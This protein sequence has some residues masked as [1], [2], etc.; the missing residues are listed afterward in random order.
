MTDVL[1]E[2]INKQDNFEIVRDQIAAILLTE[3]ANQQAL[4][5]AASEDPT[6]W[7][8]TVYTER[9]NAW[10]RYLN[11][12]PNT[13]PIVNIWY[14]NSDF[15]Q[16]GSN[17]SSRQKTVGVFNIDCYGYG[18]S[19]TDGA[20]GHVAGDKEANLEV[21]RT[22]RLVRNILMA[23]INTYLQ[24]R[25][26]VWQRWPQSVVAFQ[27]EQNGNQVQQVS[28]ARIAFQV[29]FNEFSPQTTGEPTEFAHI[30]VCRAEDGEIVLETDFDYTT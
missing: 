10:E 5:L 9:S 2:L 30:E 27:P 12:N 20:T 18:V 19:K 17:V 21:Q 15:D 8:I 16:S 24:L 11:E 28:G 14:D 23:S 26:L 25:G 22:L 3:I 1:K 29:T 13:V 7:D 6:L 4:A